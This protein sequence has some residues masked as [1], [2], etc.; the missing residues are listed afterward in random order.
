MSR[1]FESAG[2]LTFSNWSINLS[3][4]ILCRRMKKKVRGNAAFDNF[5]DFSREAKFNTK[6]KKNNSEEAL[7]LA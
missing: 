5:L 6:T 1:I 3:R 2:T 4:S 7:T